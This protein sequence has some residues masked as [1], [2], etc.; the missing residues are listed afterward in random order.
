MVSICVELVHIFSSDFF[1]ARNGFYREILSRIKCG[2]GSSDPSGLRAAIN[3][4]S[5][6]RAHV[7]LS[8]SPLLARVLVII[9]F[10]MCFP[11][12]SILSI[13]L[14]PESVFRNY[15]IKFY[16]QLY[17]WKLASLRCM[18][19]Y[20]GDKISRKYSDHRLRHNRH[21]I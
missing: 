7:H 21:F 19:I 9:A 17:I 2:W 4:C 11:K 6:V 8:C 10:I 1:K 16:K 18:F 5:T 14:W 13:Y 20:S 3:I 15:V 12:T